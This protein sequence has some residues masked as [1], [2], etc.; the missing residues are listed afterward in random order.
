MA[1]TAGDSSLPLGAWNPASEYGSNLRFSLLERRRGAHALQ[2]L[3][4][5]SNSDHLERQ[6]EETS[7]APPSP[8]PLF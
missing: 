6:P 4:R 3:Q 8:A 2:H 1:S 5:L 7:E